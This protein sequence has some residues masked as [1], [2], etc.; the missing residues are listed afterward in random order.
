MKPKFIAIL[1]LAVLFSCDKST[2]F[3]AFD[4]SFAENRWQRTD[5]KTYDVVIEKEGVYNLEIDFSYVAGMQFAEIPIYFQ[6][7]NPAGAIETKDIIL[8]TKDDKGGDVGDC[9]GDYCD[10]T[11]E[12]FRSKTLQPGAY[13]V[14]L[15][16]AFNHDYLPNVIGIGIRLS[17]AE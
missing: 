7:I 8:Q 12:V 15:T 2:V 9:A 13:K 4:S 14:R 11:H 17:K 3:K 10:M 1:L 5:V 6:F 16:N